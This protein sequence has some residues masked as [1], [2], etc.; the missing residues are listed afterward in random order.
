M[1]LST[2]VWNW[3]QCAASQGFFLRFQI[4]S[5]KNGSLPICK[6]EPCATL[7]VGFWSLRQLPILVFLLLLWLLSNSFD[8]YTKFFRSKRAVGTFLRFA[9][10]NNPEEPAPS[11]FL[12]GLLFGSWLRLQNPSLA[13]FSWELDPGFWHQKS[14]ELTVIYIYLHTHTHTH[15]IDK[16]PITSL[17]AKLH[18]QKFCQWRLTTYWLLTDS[19]QKNRIG[20]QDQ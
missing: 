6:K 13:A 5:Q 18:K 20:S 16:I 17:F 2:V 10:Q 11:F 14:L 19:L 4:M 15:T 7:V 12:E 3:L 8:A 9:L 1:R